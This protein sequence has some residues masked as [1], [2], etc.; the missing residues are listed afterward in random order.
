[1]WLCEAVRH[2]CTGGVG[3]LRPPREWPRVG[4]GLVSPVFSELGVG[5]WSRMT[6]AELDVVDASEPAT[7][8][9][10]NQMILDCE[11]SDSR[12]GT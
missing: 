2:R 3:G 12:M 6:E 8:S 5:E 9:A 11:R 10:C 1:M 7:I 4:S